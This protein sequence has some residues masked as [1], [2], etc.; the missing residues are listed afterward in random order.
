[1]IRVR[2]PPL[3]KHLTP[4]ERGRL[5]QKQAVANEYGPHDARI[6][7]AWENFRRTQLGKAVYRALRATFRSKCAFCERVNAKTADHFYPKNRYPRRMFRWAN[8]LLCCAECNPVKG[9]YFPFRKRRPVLLDPT[10]EEPLEYFTWDFQ[11]G[12]MVASTDP[13]RGPRAQ[14]TRDRFQLDEG[15]LRE[16]RR[17]QLHRVLQLLSDVVNE[18]PNLR[19]ATRERLK[20]ELHP[21]RPYL[22]IIRFLFREPN[23]YRPIVDDARSKLPDIDTWTEAWL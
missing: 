22:G 21:N 3:A 19:P 17:V 12:A 7:P 14:T 4:A 5:N 23:A 8:L 10:R 18:H 2:R 1:M 13:V 9:P 16:E 20:E 15:P 11:T 6:D